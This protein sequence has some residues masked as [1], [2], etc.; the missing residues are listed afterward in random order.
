MSRPPR[1]DAERPRLTRRIAACLTALAVGSMAAMTSLPARAVDGAQPAAERGTSTLPSVLPNPQEMTSA[2]ADMSFSGKVTVVAG[3]DADAKA[4]EQVVSILRGLPGAQVSVSRT[5]DASGDQVWVGTAETTP[6]IA[7][8]VASLGGSKADTLP[9]DGYVVASGRR[10]GHD[11]IALQG[12]DARG[13]FYAAQTLRQLVRHGEVASVTVRD[14]PLMSIRGGIEG[15][16]GI[17]WSHQ[18]RLDQFTF[19]GRHKMNTYIYTP[20]D[21]LLLRAKWRTLYSGDDLTRMKELVKGADANHVDFT[22]ALSPGNDICYSSDADFKATTAKF[23]QLRS[24]GVTSF[25]VALDDIELKFHCDADRQKYPNNGDWKWIADAQADYLN[26]LETEYVK[27]NGLPPLQTVPTNYNGSGEDP[28]KAEFGTRLDKDIRVQWTGEGVFSPSITESSVARAAQSYRTQ[29]LYIWDNFPVNDGRRNRLFLNP[30][31]NR[32]PNLYKHIDGITSNPM[33]EPYASMPALANYGDYTWSPTAYDAKASMSSVLDELAGTDEHTRAALRVFADLNQSWPYRT[34]DT[35]AP[36]LSAAVDA[37]WAARAK[38]SADSSLKSRL[39]AIVALPEALAGMS[40]QGFRRD[41][42][43]WI[44]AASQWASA[45]QHLVKMLDAIDADDGATA[46][47]EYLAARKQIDLAKQPTVD[48]QGS[49]GVLHKAVIVPSVGDGVF[50][51]FVTKASAEYTTFIGARPTS[52]KGYTG[53]AS[54]SL[55]QWQAN[56]PSRMV[57]GNLSTLYW[58]NAAPKKDSYVQVDLGSVKPIGQVAVHQAD[59]DTATGDMFY[60]AALEYSTDGST[61]TSA[62]TFDS[63]PLVKHTF[64]TP[65]QAR[66]V[67]LRA[68]DSNPGAQWV[69]IR[70]FQVSPPT[71][72]YSTNVKAAEGSSVALAFDGDVSTAFRAAAAAKT[73]DFVSFVPAKDV[74]ARQAIVVGTARGDVQVR[75]GQTWTTIGTISDDAPFHAFAVPTATTVEEVRIMLADGSPAPV[76]REMTVVDRELKATPNPTPTDKPTP[77]P[78]DRP[79]PTPTTSTPTVT[80]SAGGEHGH[81]G[82]STPTP[83]PSNGS[84]PKLP[85]TGA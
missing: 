57:D 23:D 2:G 74:T 28:Y 81:P 83:S 25:Y 9:A 77:T 46:T 62:G 14:W 50:E 22:F 18:A 42:K 78:T 5:P 29:H 24:L 76:I 3:A 6:G 20:K 32:D 66:Y 58:S 75:S 64:E 45:S 80:P 39:A 52:A 61:W 30:L 65:I 37:F 17:P 60:H 43:P 21:D 8:L 82:H 35:H 19:Y 12:K 55:G 70:E 27:K 1:A 41:A 69:K 85:H 72:A 13:T 56:S 44:T 33:I 48:D 84:R 67:R 51:A 54:S 59:D 7:E 16:Y 36:E 11:V 63:A 4:V 26:R 73:G 40:Q 47:T 34:P 68:T 10:S 49:D 31:I 15:F 53:T 79:T 38:G 71:D